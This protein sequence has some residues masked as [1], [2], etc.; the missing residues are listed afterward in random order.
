MYGAP[1]GGGGGGPP[2]MVNAGPYGAPPVHSNNPYGA[3]PA[4]PYGA[5]PSSNPYGAPPMAGGG[6]G[7]GQY[8]PV[9]GG[10]IA[11]N[12]APPNLMPI[13]ALNS[14]QN[15][16]TVKARVTQKSDIRR[17]SNARGEG[18]FFSFDLLDADGGE[19]RAVGWNDQCDRFFDQVEVGQVYLLSKAS[20]KNKRGNFNQTRHQFEIHL[21]NNS[22]LEIVQD[23]AAIPRISFN[24]TPLSQLEDTP[25]GQMVDILAV[26]ESVLDPIDI[27]R[28][29]GTQV[30]KRGVNV[31]D[32]SGRSIE[33]TLWGG[34][35]NT[36]GDELA[37]AIASG[38]HPIIA[39]KSTRVGDYNGKT[40]ST[41]ASSTVIVDPVDPPEA[42]QLRSWYDGG[43]A[44]QTAT[45]LS[46]AR[47][48]GGRVDRRVCISQ[49]RG[50]GLGLGG[51]PAWVQVLCQPIFVRNENFS[52]PACPLQYNGKTCNKKMTD[53][54]GDGTSWF[55]ERCGS[56]A[57]QPDHR[58]ILTAQV[59]DHTEA[60]WV[61]AFN[62]SA[63][64]LLGMPAGE[65]KALGDAQDPR[66][67]ATFRDAQFRL[68]VM[69][70]KVSEETYQE[71]SKLRFNVVRIDPADFAAE[72]R[73]TLDAISRL[74]RGE[75]AYPQV[76]PAAAP[77]GGAYASPNRQH[78]AGADGFGGGA[79]GGGGGG[80]GGAGYG[81]GPA[82]HHPQQQQQ[83]QQWG[84]PAGQGGYGHGYGGFMA[85]GT[86]GYGVPQQPAGY[87]GGGRW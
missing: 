86:G 3:P 29:D 31:R 66:F 63:P 18:K 10:T 53:Q 81:G 56:S 79:Y 75:Q 58:Y 87:A 25:A 74:E 50:E 1:S 42:G 38:R 11:R 40:L 84:Q 30:T 16:W 46:S 28:K 13:N 33:L 15:R 44:T 2:Q 77:Q 67:E 4:G 6:G 36:P 7:A 35:A 24:F 23:E 65:L 12:D 8:H 45:A 57:P 48:G 78:R 61:T 20:L 76:A 47:A 34:Y 26:V 72:T 83:Q 73:W 64:E 22:V 49:I 69:K 51:H 82:T 59:G 39:A 32:A 21:E 14:Y 9:A 43:G 41:V 80:Y 27:N 54:T 62:E 70:L 19:I 85:G 71:E 52:Y 60:L 5:P 37:S 17:Y 68:C 55:C